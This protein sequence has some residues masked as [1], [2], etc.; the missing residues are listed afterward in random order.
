MLNIPGYKILKRLYDS[1][2]VTIYKAIFNETKKNVILKVLK[3]ETPSQDE[4][5]EFISQFDIIKNISLD[6][7][8]KIYNIENFSGRIA[9]VLEDFDAISLKSYLNKNISLEEF[10]NIAIQLSQSIADLHKNNIIHNNLNPENILINP[11][12]MCIKIN[13]FS[14]A[15]LINQ[16]FSNQMFQKKSL[17]YVSPEQ[18]GRMNKPIDY[19]TDLYSL[20]I[21]FY[22]MIT[23]EL[24]FKSNDAME[25]IHFHIAKKAIPPYKLKKDIPKVISNII[26]KLLEKNPEDRYKSGYGLKSDFEFCMEKLNNNEEI[27]NFVLGKLDVSDKFQISQKI[28]GREDEIN[29]LIIE[30]EKKNINRDFILFEGSNGI[31]KTT[32]INETQKIISSKK[33][34]FLLA[35]FDKFKSETPYFSIFQAFQELI[36]RLLIE[37][38]EKIIFWKNKLINELGE[39]LSVII[40][41]L[42]EIEYITGK[43]DLNT[44][45]DFSKIEINNILYK[46]I[47]IFGNNEN[48]FVLFLDNLQWIDSASINLLKTI[49]KSKNNNLF[50]IGAF[51]NKLLNSSQIFFNELKLL[52]SDIK[53]LPISALTK[54]NIIELIIDT[55]NSKTNDTNIL[56]EIIYSKTKGIPYFV[57]QFLNN[58]YNEGLIF[59]KSGFGWKWDINEIKKAKLKKNV[60]DLMVTKISKLEINTQEVLK[61]A[62]CL[63]NE[64]SFKDLTIINKKSD[65]DTFMDL[66]EALNEGLI[67]IL[68]DTNKFLNDIV[69]KASYSLI[70]NDNKTKIHYD[71]GEIL[72]KET[73]EEDIE[74]NIFNIVTQ[75]NFGIKIIN[76]KKEKY[77][78]AELNLIA[79]KR[80][81]ISSSNDI[82]LKYFKIAF[83]L[84]PK[85]SWNEK[86][87]LTFQIYLELYEYYYLIMNF[88]E[89]EK[90]FKI[91]LIHVKNQDELKQIN[92]LKVQLDLINNKNNNEFENKDK[93]KNLF[94]FNLK[95]NNGFEF[96]FNAVMKAFQ[97][98]SAEI[99]LD[100]LL[101]KLM[102]IL[103][104]NAGAEKG[105]LILNNNGNLFIEAEGS[106]IQEKTNI[107]QSIRFEESPNICHSIINY[108]AR[109]QEDIVLNDALKDSI[110]S[111]DSYIIKNK[112]RSILCIPIIKQS[113]LLGILYLENNLS[114]DVFTPNRLEILKL[115]S[116]QAAISLENAS[117]Y[118]QMK[119][120]NN[121]LEKNNEE[122]KIAKED[123]EKINR[124]KSQFLGNISHELRT[125]LNSILGF[126]DLLKNNNDEKVTKYAERINNNGNRLMRLINDI[127]ELS[128]LDAE[129]I[130]NKNSFFSIKNLA[131][132]KEEVKKYL[133]DKIIDINIHFAQDLPDKICADMSKIY[134][135]LFNIV[136]NASKYTHKGFIDVYF[137]FNN[138]SKQEIKVDVKDSGIGII[139]SDFSNIFEEFY[140][141]AGEKQNFKGSGLGLTTAKKL[142][143]QLEGNIS[144]SSKLNIC[145]HFTFTFKIHG[146]EEEL[147]GNIILNKDFSIIYEQL[148][149]ISEYRF[150][151]S[152]KI[153]KDL[154][155]LLLITPED[156]HEEINDL[157]LK[158]KSKNEKEYKILLMKMINK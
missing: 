46:F 103:I 124:L 27:Q 47:N 74:D 28:Y 107:R 102:K 75:L 1:S 116:S 130:P 86:Y 51:D 53:I 35:T 141:V 97:T 20:G 19:R 146:F 110:F 18:T 59:Y 7:I 85:N 48:P 153:N 150:F 22:E 36:R 30:F 66:S 128:I 57:K 112:P 131:T 33:S 40:D 148:K 78:L 13:D 101:E 43:I 94:T 60:F 134:K 104:E 152:S 2:N 89:A 41:N 117:F 8:T 67:L 90:L 61:L 120:L 149:K 14:S 68:E 72:L 81:K 70:S 82:S 9:L 92:E 63:G 45:I 99:I 65:V 129:N 17:L 49:I 10:L 31:G 87:K 111:S 29:Y 133:Q 73:K 80:S 113:K 23:S 44:S 69:H 154:E 105:F 76:K 132:V 137:S 71:I 144:V 39:D 145:S 96:D 50:L 108:V 21:I 16:N 26:M 127:T 34:P 42:P 15:S 126:S 125:P 84:L 77:K 135:V 155:N 118:D 143:Q 62:S 147:N 106:I 114:T 79:G 139:E 55:F 25:L 91:L 151:E 24:P 3:N 158:L 64:F 38:Q 123:A 98:L 109:T 54:D 32:I 5:E 4:I 136:E 88:T 58:I 115:L 140:Q 100:N 12:T 142:V 11:E 52:K 37:S 83:D 157:I 119:E 56:S 6:G 122:L 93:S 138:D 95:S 156:L 121:S